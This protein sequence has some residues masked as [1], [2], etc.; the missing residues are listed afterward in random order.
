[1]ATWRKTAWGQT[2][3]AVDCKTMCDEIAK[4]FGLVARLS[5]SFGED[6]PVVVGHLIRPGIGP[7]VETVF[8]AKHTQYYRQRPDLVVMAY[9][10]LWD[11]YGQADSG[12]AGW[13]SGDRHNKTR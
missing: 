13:A 2:P 6:G 5:V 4:D 10:V 11:L 7:A 3:D 1:M 12:V 9:K 8:V